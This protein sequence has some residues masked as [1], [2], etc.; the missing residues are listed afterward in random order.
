MDYISIPFSGQNIGGLRSVY[1][2]R[3]FD[4]QTAFQFYFP[5]QT[6]ALRIRER[7]NDVGK[8]FQQTVSF[9]LAKLTHEAMFFLKEN[10]FTEFVLTC[11]DQN[12]IL[13]EVGT[14]DCPCEMIAEAGTGRTQADLNAM[15][16]EF[17]V[18]HIDPPK[19]LNEF[20]ANAITY[21][22]DFS[23]VNQV[24]IT[25]QLG[26]RVLVQVEDNAGNVIEC[27]IRHIN[28]N[29]FEVKFYENKSG[30]IVWI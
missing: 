26:R 16:L 19:I 22:Q 13:Y 3:V 23:N 12:G 8:L 10:R 2:A 11:E 24:L 9:T 28:F 18:L 21:Q 27:Q 1:I 4:I 30:K 5:E 6:A 20:M 29:Q 25:H 7:P 15:E 14:I 17:S